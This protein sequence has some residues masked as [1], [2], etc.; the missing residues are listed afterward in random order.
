MEHAHIFDLNLMLLVLIL[1]YYSHSAPLLAFYVSLNGTR[2]FLYIQIDPNSSIDL[3]VSACRQCSSSELTLK[4]SPL[5][6]TWLLII[7]S[8]LANY[9]FEN[10]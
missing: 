9:G 10:Q 5:V 3:S 4:A 1:L 7:E 6:A 8:N 2:R